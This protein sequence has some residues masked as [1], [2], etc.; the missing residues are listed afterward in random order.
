MIASGNGR[1]T[2]DRMA[3][4]LMRIL[5]HLVVFMSLIGLWETAVRTGLITSIIIPKPSAVFLAIIDLYLI[6]GAIYRHFF[7]TL[8]EAVLGFLIGALIAVALAVCSSLSEP[9]KRYVS[10]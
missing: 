6:E 2:S 3:D 1:L 5:P 4:R 10:P 8:A 9:F 7:I